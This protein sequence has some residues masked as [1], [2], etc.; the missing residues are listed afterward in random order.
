MTFFQGKHVKKLSNFHKTTSPQP[1]KRLTYRRLLLRAGHIMNRQLNT[2]HSWA[3]LGILVSV[4]T[5]LFVIQWYSQMPKNVQPKHPTEVSQSTTAAT[6][7]S[8]PTTTATAAVVTETE[9]PVIL[10][11]FNDLYATN[12][13]FVGWLTVANTTIDYPVVQGTDN[14]EYLH[15][16]FYGVESKYGTVFLDYSDNFMNLIAPCNLILYGHNMKDDSM[17]G[18]L[19][20]YKKESFFKDN[21]TFTFDTIY[22]DYTWEVFSAYVTS[23]D[24]YYNVTSFPNESSWE[25]F[26]QTCA[27]KSM[28]KTNVVPSKDDIILTLSTCTYEFDNARF[29]VQA[30]LVKNNIP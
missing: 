20:K 18:E 4:I 11:K 28:Y 22:Q 8:K 24:F 9:S 10:T 26:L 30:R 5:L 7:T 19:D 13:D 1:S 21:P 12:P 14:D 23:V 3:F 6:S 27:D 2:L 29:V 17:F 25:V 15:L 16:N